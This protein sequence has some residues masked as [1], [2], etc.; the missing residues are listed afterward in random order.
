MTNISFFFLS[1]NLVIQPEV[2]MA[3]YQRVL[4]V[5]E[6]NDKMEGSYETDPAFVKFLEED[7]KKATKLLSADIQLEQQ[8]VLA[9]ATGTFNNFA[10]FY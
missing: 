2:F 3:P 10:I 1:D 7:Q 6:A 9:A 4:L 5:K 8:K